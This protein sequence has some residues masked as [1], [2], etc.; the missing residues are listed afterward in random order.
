MAEVGTLFFEENIKIIENI[1]KVQFENQEK[2]IVNLI[3]ANQKITMDEI[4]K[5]QDESRKLAK[6]VVDLKQSLEF[7]EN[8][9]EEKVKKLDEKHASLENQCNEPYN[10]SL[11]SEYFTIS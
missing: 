11:E 4:K 9:L 2:N 1:F 7:T 3:S 5:T 10:N 6:E 8:V